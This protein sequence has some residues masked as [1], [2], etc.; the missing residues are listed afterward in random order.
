M[1]QQ[2]VLRRLQEVVSPCV[3]AILGHPLPA[4]LRQA[5]PWSDCRL[6]RLAWKAVSTGE[7]YTPPNADTCFQ[8]LAHANRGPGVERKSQTRF[9]DSCSPPGGCILTLAGRCIDYPKVLHRW[10]FVK[11]VAGNYGWLVSLYG[12]TGS[13]HLHFRASALTLW[14]V[15]DLKQRTNVFTSTDAGFAF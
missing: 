6:S 1:W 2:L 8:Q 9:L 15:F 4:D 14:T 7:V 13:I 3:H 5:C 12:P 10:L 11:G